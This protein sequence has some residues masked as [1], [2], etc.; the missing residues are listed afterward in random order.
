M[1]K[2]KA[3]TKIEAGIAVLLLFAIVVVSGT[4][5]I[6]D[7]SVSVDGTTLDGNTFYGWNA[8]NATMIRN[9]NG[10]YWE[11][12]GENIQNAIND[13]VSGGVVYLPSGTIEVTTQILMDDDIW[14]K[15]SGMT[16]V[17]HI[18]GNTLTS[19]NKDNVT[20][21]DFKITGNFG[22][23]AWASTGNHNGL[24]VENV[25]ATITNPSISGAFVVIANNDYTYSDITFIDCRAI[26]CGNFGW[27]FS[28][29]VG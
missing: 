20:F 23:Y 27:M 11:P 1:K 5:T 17:L 4:V 18:T 16:T 14:L 6:T 15:G 19:G 10:R 21:S 22:I 12:T 3:R 24:W 13:L 8:S 9:S 28:G 2:I 7:V 29:S 26:D 25:E